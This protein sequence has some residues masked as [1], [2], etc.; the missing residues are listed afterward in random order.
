MYDHDTFT[1]D[2]LMGDAEFSIGKFV[3]AIRMSYQSVPNGTIVTR[4]QPDKDNCLSQESC[5]VWYDGR[6]VQDLFLRL[7]NVE[8]GE[9]ELQLNWI[10][11]PGVRGL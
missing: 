6:V 7:Q 1:K 3:E 2:D 10:S 8:C 9:V 4:I 11:L 5:I